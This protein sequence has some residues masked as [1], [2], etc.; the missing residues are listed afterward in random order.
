MIYVYIYKLTKPSPLPFYLSLSF[1]SLSL[2]CLFLF[3]IHFLFLPYSSSFL[4]IER[5]MNGKDCNKR[6]QPYP[7]MQRRNTYPFRTLICCCLR[8]VSFYLWWLLDFFYGVQVFSSRFY[9]RFYRVRPIIWLTQL[10]THLRRR[11]S[12]LGGYQTY[13]VPISD[14]QIKN[15][16]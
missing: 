4:L 2:K 10:I 5:A 9:D 16:R 11:T 14:L 8:Y 12:D 13:S 15:H 3:L 7:P 1:S 6:L